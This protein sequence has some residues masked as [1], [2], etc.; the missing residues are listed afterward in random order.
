MFDAVAFELVGVGGA[1]DLIPRDLGGNDL[2]DDIFVGEADDQ[3]IFGG[4]VFVLSLGYETLACVIVG[5]SSL[6]T[7]ILGLIATMR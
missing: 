3:A 5:L 1:K 7:L 2:T 6:T 4:I